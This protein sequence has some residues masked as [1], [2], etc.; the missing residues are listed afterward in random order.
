[1]LINVMLI[2]KHVSRIDGGKLFE[3]LVSIQ[4]RCLFYNSMYKV[5]TYLKAYFRGRSLMEEGF[6]SGTPPPFTNFDF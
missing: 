1:M 6:G 4:W 5:G 2:K 3:E